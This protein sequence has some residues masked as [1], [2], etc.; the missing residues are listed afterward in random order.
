M[1]T[2][3]NKEMADA[4][5]KKEQKKARRRELYQ[6][7]KEYLTTKQKVLYHE[8]GGKDYKAQYYQ[9]HREKLLK[10]NTDKYQNRIKLE[11][12]LKTITQ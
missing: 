3:I 11:K 2:P 12:E 10:Y 6:L 5:V 1:D 9:I 7:N 8:Y 4:L